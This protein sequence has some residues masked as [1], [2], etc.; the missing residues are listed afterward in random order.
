MAQLVVL[1]SDVV[2]GRVV[3]VLGSNPTRGKIFTSSIGI[4]D[5][6][7]LSVHIWYIYIRVSFP[8]FRLTLYLHMT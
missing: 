6:L 8:I 3:E 4:V 7:D 5:L 1:M 2:L